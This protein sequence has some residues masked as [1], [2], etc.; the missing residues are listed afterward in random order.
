MVG[1]GV[2]DGLEEQVGGRRR[3]DG[4]VNGDDG[5]LESGESTVED[6]E[7]FTPMRE[8][9]IYLPEAKRMSSSARGDLRYVIMVEQSTTPLRCSIPMLLST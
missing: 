6:E 1:N 8:L 9:R 3:S 7:E 5:V 4:L 2:G